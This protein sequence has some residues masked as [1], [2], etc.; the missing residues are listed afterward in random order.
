MK[1]I[2]VPVKGDV[3]I[4]DINAEFYEILGNSNE[5]INC[6]MRHSYEPLFSSLIGR[7]KDLESIAK[8]KTIA[9]AVVL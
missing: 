6:R 2:S 5:V 9:E 7:K 8:V 4:W 1:K 3:E